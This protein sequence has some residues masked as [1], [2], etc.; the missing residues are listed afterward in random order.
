MT[1][2]LII[3]KIVCV[4]GPWVLAEL[5]VQKLCGVYDNMVDVDIHNLQGTG[6]MPSDLKV[7]TSQTPALNTRNSAASCQH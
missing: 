3:R 7:H 6:I 2:P 5:T 4:G 1:F